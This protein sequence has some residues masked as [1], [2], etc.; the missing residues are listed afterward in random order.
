MVNVFAL[1]FLCSGDNVLLLHRKDVSFGS[2]LY[3]LSGGKV[4]QGET[5]RQA[6]VREVCEELGLNI[7]ESAFELVHTFHRKGI[8]TELVAL[9]FKA[10]ISGITPRNNEPTKHDDMKLF[11]LHQL[12]ENIIPAHKQAVE[13]IAKD[14]SY[15]EHGW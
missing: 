6:I 15:S 9:V 4:E 10:D 13:C 11:N 3:G 5:A 14:V 12:P 8:D 1:A 2:G 7:S